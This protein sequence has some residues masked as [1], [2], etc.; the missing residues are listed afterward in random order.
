M[1]SVI[2]IAPRPHEI[3]F[4]T[5]LSAPRLPRG[6][7]LAPSEPGSFVITDGGRRVYVRR[8]D[9]IVNE[10]DAD[11]LARIRA[12][13]PDPIFYSVDFSDIELCRVVLLS[14]VDDANLLI[15]ND[16]GVLLRGSDFVRV[17]RSQSNWDWRRDPVSRG[18]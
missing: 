10:L 16:H 7:S 18:S 14:L 3:E 11:E 12:L 5:R 1:E 6:L 17:L 9:S 15:D 4:G 13:I 2:V 8:N